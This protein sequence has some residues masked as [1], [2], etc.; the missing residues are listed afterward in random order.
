MGVQLVTF[1]GLHVLGN[2]RELERL[3]SQRSRAALLIYLTIERRV[4][5]EA[6]TAIFWP[7]SDTENARHAL[8]QS[9]YHLR[10]IVGGTDWI[11]SRA[12]EIVVRGEIGSDATAFSDAVECGNT[13]RAVRLYG[14]PFLDGVHLVDLQPWESW[15][16]GRRTKYARLFR[17]ACRDLLD[18]RLA[19]GDLTGA[20]A[21]AERWTAPDP[22]DD[23][24]QHRLIAALAVAGERAEAIRQYETYARLLAPE[25]LEPLDETRDVVEQLRARAALMPTR[26]MALG[27][28]PVIHYA[29]CPRRGGRRPTR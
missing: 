18:A 9:L 20:I 7:E 1:G 21:V 3:L 23:E 29:R 24:A 27:S 17:K 12:H 2:P 28:A 10:K 19:A 6:L 11:D 14:G 13:E 22:T 8:R 16:D 26:H 4:S 15:V 25:G 5:R